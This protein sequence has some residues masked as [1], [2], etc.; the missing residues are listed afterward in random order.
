MTS[1][2]IS[3]FNPRSPHGERR[4]LRGR[5]IVVRD[6]STHAP[7]TGSD[8]P[9]AWAC[10]ASSI[11]THAPRTGSDLRAAQRHDEHGHN[12]NPRSPH[13]ER[14]AHLRGAAQRLVI[15]THAPRTGSDARPTM[16][17]ARSRRNFNPRSPH[18][19]RQNCPPQVQTSK[20]IST[21][22]P[23]TGS[24]DKC[25]W[26]ISALTYFNPRSPHG[27]RRKRIR[28]GVHKNRFQPTLPARGA[29]PDDVDRLE[30]AYI[31]THAPRTGSDHMAGLAERAGQSISTHA[32]RTGSDGLTRR[33]RARFPIS[34]HAPRTGSDV[35]TL[36]PET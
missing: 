7:R 8:F 1:S 32:P 22:A 33:L 16:T 31:S 2:A 3:N 19:E 28:S 9:P 6:I 12:F 13:G 20:H 5:A 18:G 24:D 25:K 27:E 15:S 26:L 29:T 30:I 4:H 34:T 36:P 17:A 21:H 11:S 10:A 14:R 35:A 23:R